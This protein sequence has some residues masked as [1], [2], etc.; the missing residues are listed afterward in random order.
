VTPRNYGGI[1]M[2][3]ITFIFIIGILAYIGL[4]IEL[5]CMRRQMIRISIMNNKERK[6]WEDGADLSDWR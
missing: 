6:E 1:S 3:N 5:Y 4:V 2:E